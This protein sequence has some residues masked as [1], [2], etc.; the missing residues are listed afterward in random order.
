M[1]EQA[2]RYLAI[3]R[4]AAGATGPAKPSS[5]EEPAAEER[6]ASGNPPNG[7]QQ[8]ETARYTYADRDDGSEETT[9]REETQ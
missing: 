7:L 9:Q 2:Q 5:C 8:Q 4:K 3:L 6:K 1:S